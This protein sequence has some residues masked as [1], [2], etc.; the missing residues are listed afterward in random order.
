MLGKSALDHI[1][2][3][4]EPDPFHLRNYPLRL[5]PWGGKSKTLG[6]CPSNSYSKMLRK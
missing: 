3:S 4:L 1:G 5:G 6:S 2:K